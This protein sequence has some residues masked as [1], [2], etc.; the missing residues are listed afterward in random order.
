[1]PGKNEQAFA[2]KGSVGAGMT[3]GWKQAGHLHESSE[4]GARAILKG[5]LFSSA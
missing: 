1:M 4:P 2:L 3:G 5:Q